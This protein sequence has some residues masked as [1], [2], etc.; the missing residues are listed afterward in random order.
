M[1]N[2]LMTKAV[3]FHVNGELVKLSGNT[4]RNYLVRGNGDVTDQEIVMFINLC[5]FQKLNP[6]LNEAYLI[7]FKGSPA[8]IVV[9]KEAFMKRAESH[10]KY[11]G[12]QAGVIVERDGELIEIEGAVKLPKDRLVGGWCKVYREDR[13][14][15]IV[16]K[17][18]FSE[19]SKNQATW[20]Q[21]P[22]NMIR[23][24]AI[25]NGLREAFPESLGAMYT[26]DDA[27]VKQH[28]TEKEIAEGITNNANT[29]IIDIEYKEALAIP[30]ETQEPVQEPVIQESLQERAESVQPTEGPGF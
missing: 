3:E 17:I 29:E 12:F 8:Q 28:S 16:T 13:K 25:V 15:P 19:F 6:F 2:S 14:V 20:K 22:L 27:D 26:E 9:S 11:Q 4:V 10:P 23:K 30:D 1:P 21:M 18:M 24:S 5:R 7:K